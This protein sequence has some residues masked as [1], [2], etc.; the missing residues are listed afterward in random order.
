MAQALGRGSSEIIRGAWGLHKDPLTQRLTRSHEDGS[1]GQGGPVKASRRR[2]V[3]RGSVTPEP[4]EAAS[5]L[6]VD[7]RPPDLQNGRG[8]D[9][10]CWPLSLE[11]CRVDKGP[12][13]GMGTTGLRWGHP[14][15]QNPTGRLWTRTGVG[16]GP[17]QAPGRV[18]RSTAAAHTLPRAS[19]CP[20]PALLGQSTEGG[21]STLVPGR[22]LLG[23]VPADSAHG[24]ASRRT[25]SL[26]PAAS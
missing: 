14:W 16:M 7:V 19:T 6:H 24:T 18:L 25:A 5:Q 2:G 12:I 9:L 22:R 1:G 15:R 3:G 21:S 26:K 10:L 8:I 23:C 11:T 20:S 13:V 17:G 4:P